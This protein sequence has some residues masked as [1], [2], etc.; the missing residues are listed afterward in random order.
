MRA[1]WSAGDGCWDL[2]AVCLNVHSEN[3]DLSIMLLKSGEMAGEQDG[4]NEYMKEIIWQTEKL[5]IAPVKDNMKCRKYQKGRTA[6]IIYKCPSTLGSGSTEL[7]TLVP[8]L[9]HFLF[10]KTFLPF[11]RNHLLFYHYLPISGPFLP[12]GSK[13]WKPQWASAVL[14]DTPVIMR[15]AKGTA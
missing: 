12:L 14:W 15:P 3:L 11:L 5:E 10:W 8:A 1:L 6:Q 4:F 7:W 13:N 2:D 9:S